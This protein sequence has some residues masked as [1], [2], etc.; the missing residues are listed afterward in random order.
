MNRTLRL[1]CVVALLCSVTPARGDLAADVRSILAD[2]AFRKASVGVEVIRLDGTSAG[3]TSVCS[4]NGTVPLIPASN[5]KLVTTAAALELLGRD[6]QFRTVLARGGG[7][8]AIIGDGDPALGDAEMLRKLGWDVQ[9]VFQNWAEELKRRNVRSV[10][11]VLVDDSIFDEELTH[12]NWPPEQE[13]KRYVAQVGGLNLNANCVDFFLRT[14][15]PGQNVRFTTDPATSY[16]NIGNACRTGEKSAVWLSRQRGTNEIVLRGEIDRSNSEPLSVTI[17]DPAMFT[18]TVLAEVLERG[19]V[20]VEGGVERD[21]TVLGQMGAPAQGTGAAAA[22]QWVA[23][24]V[25]QT[26]IATVLARANKDSMNLYAEALCKRI[27]AATSGRSGS[28]QNGIAAMGAYLQSAGISSDE[29]VL[30]DGSGLSRKNRISARAIA[31]VLAHVFAS[32]DREPFLAS[33]S[34]AGGDGTLE[35]RFRGSDLQGRV[36]GK[37]GYINGVSSLSGY[38]KAN[39]SHWYAFSIL[40][41]DVT[42]I[43]ACKQAQEKIVRAIDARAAPVAAVQER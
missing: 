17:H 37:S 36:F 28:W 32:P 40:M 34:V 4:H 16:I 38:L 2:K 1:A 29:F 3:G 25:H 12:P 42:D 15:D 18:G 6:F 7:D 19:G 35:K 21:R 14:G 39:D 26:P 43:A 30:D 8:I 33:L 22:V 13:H 27:G 23:V 41:N 11:R 31:R 24:A 5:L 20:A 10:H 9:T